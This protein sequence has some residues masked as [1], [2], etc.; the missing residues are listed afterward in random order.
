MNFIHE[1]LLTGSGS[2]RLVMTSPEVEQEILERSL[3]E[4]VPRFAVI[5]HND[6]INSM[7]HVVDALLKSIP[8]LSEQD[9]I[10]VMMG[11]HTDGKAVIT[12]CPRETAEFYRDRLQS[13]SIGAS[14][15]A[16]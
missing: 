7:E 3:T 5:L 15:E 14:I 4:H 8:T 16:A 1:S 10:R 2:D 6:D 13:F 12:V 9:A 11:A